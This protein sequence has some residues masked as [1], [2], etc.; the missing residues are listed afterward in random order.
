MEKVAVLGEAVG[1]QYQGITDRTSTNMINGVNGPTIIGKFKRGR[2][3][4]AM[5]IHSGNIR[6]QLG[7]DPDNPDYIAVQTMLDGKVPS[8]KVIRVAEVG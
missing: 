5:L 1:I 7:Y 2:V 8:V 3:D 4:R 6:S